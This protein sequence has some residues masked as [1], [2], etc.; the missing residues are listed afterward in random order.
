MSTQIPDNYCGHCGE[1]LAPGAIICA[2]CNTPVGTPESDQFG[3]HPT[4]DSNIPAVN[5]RPT[6]SG[7]LISFNSRPTFSSKI[8]PVDGTAPSSSFSPTQRSLVKI[9]IGQGIAI[10][11]LLLI[12]IALLTHF[13]LH[14]TPNPSASQTATPTP[15]MLYQADWSDG[16]N[17]WTGS[18]DWK[19]LNGQLTND[20]TKSIH[21]LAM[22][23]MQVPFDLS[24]TSDYQIEARLQVTRTTHAAG[25]GFFVRYDDNGHGYIV[26]AGSPL[27]GPTTLF[28]ITRADS[29]HTP[30]QQIAF[31]PGTAWHTYRIEVQHDHI[32]VF[33]D[34]GFVMDVTNTTYSSGAF[35]GL[36]DSNTQLSIS[37]FTIESL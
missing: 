23:T 29:W 15:R 18:A 10:T 34:G 9:I 28:E 1:P 31:T 2:H 8:I 26:G 3:A 4:L 13:S 32:I 12:V 17:G 7:K 14:I 37:S 24:N 21:N 11:V 19:A 27:D 30:L 16:L 25:F 5:S 6:V 36:W 35:V 33:I 22:P 20:G